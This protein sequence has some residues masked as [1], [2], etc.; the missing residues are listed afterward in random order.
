MPRYKDE[1]NMTPESVRRLA[2][3]LR[4]LAQRYEDAAQWMEDAGI[5]EI[6]V[7]YGKSLDDAIGD[8]LPKHIGSVVS[9]FTAASMKA[10]IAQPAPQSREIAARHGKKPKEDGDKPKG[11]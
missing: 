2:A 1:T 9:S 5:G 11:K 6:G 10:A 4:D 8:V 3:R 7:L